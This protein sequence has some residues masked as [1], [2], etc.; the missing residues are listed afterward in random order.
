MRLVV[1]E[2]DYLVLGTK[3]EKNQ[4]TF[5]FE[6]EKEDVCNIILIE[7]ATMHTEKVLVPSTFCLGSLYSVTVSG[8][9]PQDYN[10]I[11]EINGKTKMDPYAKVIVGREIWNDSTRVE[12]DYQLLSGF[13]TDSF[14]WG[15][16]VFPEV[17]KSQMIMY[18]LHVRGFTMG[19]SS[20][21]KMKG[22][23]AALRNKIPYLKELGVTT[24]ELMPVYEFEE[25]PVP[26][27]TPD[28]PAYV[29]WEAASGDI[30][31]PIPVAQK[32][33]KLNFWGYGAG[34][35]FAVKASYASKPEKASAEYKRLIKTLHENG[36]ECVMEMFFPEGTSHNL[37]LDVLRFW[38]KEYHVDG[39]HL[40]G[41]N[42]PII[43]IVQ[44]A[45]LSRT[46]IFA[47]DFY[48][49]RSSHAY[50]NLYI[51][52]S[53]YEYPAR[54]LLNHYN[55][56]ITEFVNQQKK[57]SDEYGFVN[58]IASN[59]GFTLADLFM[60]NDKHNEANGENNCDGTDYNLS[61]NYGIE[62]PTKKKYIN[63]LRR[64]RMHTACMML[65]FAQGVPLIMAGDE[66]GNSQCGN[67]NAYCQDNAIGWV[68]WSGFK[69]M[70]KERQFLQQLIA[71]RKRH[72]L[73][74]REV[75]F[76]FNDYKAMGIP[77]LSYHGEYAWISQL[78]RGRKSLGMLYS[79]AYADEGQDNSDIYIGYNFYSDEVQ[80]A[81][82]SLTG[83]KTVEK[84]WYLLMD[85]DKAQPILEEEQL[86]E[87]QQYVT[88]AP[89]S[90]CVLRG[91][92]VEVKAAK[93]RKKA[94]R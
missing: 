87:G 39:F 42:V 92:N 24:L 62:G 38:V 35:Y 90:I 41:P 83:A 66:F 77:D 75:P 84:R 54:Q 7:K 8:I 33:E 26:I 61:N 52:K 36:M 57:Q 32:E 46:K 59:D 81:L 70:A 58:F 22:T 79:G 73:I 29:K 60:Y 53:E 82:P 65:M 94:K 40:L 16:D 28:V 93:K 19:S 80:L 88:M 20:A 48:G 34:N 45:A 71:F 44:D 78:D 37:I 3:V 49:V 64:T 50:K 5:T 31:K 15:E 47:Q 17:L 11:Y 4:V 69:K 63:S 72:G 25:M 27:E 51:Y 86:L 74:A 9:H 89:H 43:G 55:C 10:Y 12:N 91:E 14:A 6:G 76:H 56:D 23:F 85:S 21:G 30:I 2:G 18:K 1:K 13:L 68:D 67:N